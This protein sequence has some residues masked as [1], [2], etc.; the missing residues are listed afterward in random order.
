[1]HNI[2]LQ[3]AVAKALKDTIVMEIN[4]IN[5]LKANKMLIYKVADLENHISNIKEYYDDGSIDNISILN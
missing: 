1:M 3:T 5:Q 4:M 2:K